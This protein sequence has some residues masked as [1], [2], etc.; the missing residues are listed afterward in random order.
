MDLSSLEIACTVAAES[1]VTRAAR[2]LGRAPS[3]VTIRIQQLERQLGVAL[4]SRDGKRMSLTREGGTFLGYA[5]RL[6]ALAQEARDAVKPLVPE[7][8]LR[9][10]SMESAAASRLP[11]ALA[12]FHVRWPAVSI[13]L[14][15][16]A[17][18]ELV[19]DVIEDRLDCALIARPPGEATELAEVAAER[20]F[21]EELLIVMPDDHPDIGSAADLRVDTLTVLEPGCTYRRIAEGWSRPSAGLRAREVGSYH[22]ILASV[23]ARES[24]GVMPRSVLDLMPRP[25]PLRTYSL[26]GVDTLLIR[27]PDHRPSAFDAFMDVLTAEADGHQGGRNRSSPTG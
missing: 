12:R 11:E 1:S 13:S 23:A 24:A 3:N 27:R 5:K 21:T 17:S 4:F 22:A 18:R 20:V 26:G 7:G 15:I 19:R 10:G 2:L 14:A 16:G 25:S 8:S 9:V 6:L